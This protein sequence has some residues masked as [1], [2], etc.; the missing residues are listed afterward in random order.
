MIT[1]LNNVQLTINAAVSFK[2]DSMTDKQTWRG[3]IIGVVGYDV[4]N[5]YEEIYAA[6]NNMVPAVAKLEASSLTYILVKCAD[7]VIRP[8]ATDWIIEKTFQRTDN[9][10]DASIVIHNVSDSELVNIITYIRSLGF[11]VT[12]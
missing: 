11:D 12:K 5:Q 10:A 2:L 7:G 6:H 3:R 4:A 8:F 9:V 1:T